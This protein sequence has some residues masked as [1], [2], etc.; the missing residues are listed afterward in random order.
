[1]LRGSAEFYVAKTKDLLVSRSIPSITGFSS[2]YDNLG[3][4]NNHGFELTLNATPVQNKFMT[5]DSSL[6]FSLNRR[7]IVHLLRYIRG[8]I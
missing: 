7:K 8:H 5:W 3:Q 1:M 6:T 4:L 2:I